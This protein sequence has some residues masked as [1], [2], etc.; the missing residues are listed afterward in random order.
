MSI[1]FDKVHRRGEGAQPQEV[2]SHRP[3]KP[4]STEY[5]FKHTLAI[6]LKKNKSADK[7]EDYAAPFFETKETK[8]PDKT[9]SI[10]VHSIHVLPR[11]KEFGLDFIAKSEKLF[12]IHVKAQAEI[13]ALEVK[14]TRETKHLNEY[15]ANLKKAF[16]ARLDYLN[17]QKLM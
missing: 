12:M 3:I 10:T 11:P 9:R 2:T 8:K 4:E 6:S 5:E 14:H 1:D 16:Q 17:Q 13:V 15:W 7:A